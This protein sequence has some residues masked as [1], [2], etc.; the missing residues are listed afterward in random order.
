MNPEHWEYFHSMS[1][2]LN[3]MRRK[4]VREK[5]NMSEKVNEKEI[6]KEGKRKEERRKEGK[7][8]E[9]EKDRC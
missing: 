9:I 2:K 4:G 1:S 8:K 3:W 6:S 5:Q 7:V